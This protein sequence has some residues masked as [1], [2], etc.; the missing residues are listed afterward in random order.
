MSRRSLARP[1][2]R[3]L[4][5]ASQRCRC[6]Q[7]ALIRAYELALPVVREPLAEKRSA[8][9][10]TSVPMRHFVPQKLLGG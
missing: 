5:R 6:E 4:I 3:S 7:Q 9:A 2:T 10:P 8:K 1:R